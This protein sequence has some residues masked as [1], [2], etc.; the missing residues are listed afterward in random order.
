ML[1]AKYQFKKDLKASIGKR[2]K[3]TETSL[4]SCEYR[5]SGRFGVVG[6]SASNRRWYA[7]VTM[8]EGKIIKVR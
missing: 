4:F 8:E 7:Q 2:L 1:V 3:I 5:H 6:P